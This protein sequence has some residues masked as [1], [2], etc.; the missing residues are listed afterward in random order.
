[1]DAG[2]HVG[3]M[4]VAGRPNGPVAARDLMPLVYT[5]LSRIARLLLRR[6][7]PAA[8]MEPA[9]LVHEAWLR[10]A[11]QTRA[12]WRSRAHFLA[13]AARAMRRILINHAHARRAIRRG[14]RL[15]RVPLV[16]AEMIAPPP[17]F[18]SL[19]LDEALLQLRRVD[20][21]R[22]RV[23]EL[24]FFRGLDVREAAQVL[25][26]SPRT[27]ELDWR[28]ARAWLHAHLTGEGF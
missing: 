24:R 28:M 1:M 26:V 2:Y 16:E 10:L 9:A 14:G 11:P 23:V 19:D 12:R 21:R 27:V 13:V 15:R 3:I 5:D 8:L 17:E 22:C 20:E 7:R 25:G 4:P 6:E 18:D